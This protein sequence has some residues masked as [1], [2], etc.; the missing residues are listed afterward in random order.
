MYQ[1]MNRVN[2]QR[3][4]SMESFSLPIDDQRKYMHNNDVQKTRDETTEFSMFSN[5]IV[6]DSDGS[7][8]LTDETP[9]A[10]T[11]TD[12]STS[13]S[14]IKTELVL[15]KIVEEENQSSFV[16]ERRNNFSD[17]GVT[18]LVDSTQPYDRNVKANFTNKAESAVVTKTIPPEIEAYLNITKKKQEGDYELDYDEPTLPPSLPN[19]KYVFNMHLLFKYS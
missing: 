19:L 15:K 5:A 7:T 17:I 16:E 12:I 6:A 18:N 4:T 11:I 8:R 1:E 2:D 9:S 14:L 10:Q 3:Q 13:I